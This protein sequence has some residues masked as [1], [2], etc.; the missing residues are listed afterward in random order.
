MQTLAW[1]DGR[2]YCQAKRLLIAFACAEDGGRFL[3]AD[4]HR[5]PGGERVLPGRLLWQRVPALPARE[6]DQHLRLTERDRQLTS[7]TIMRGDSQL[8]CMSSLAMILIDVWFN[9]LKNDGYFLCLPCRTR[10]SSTEA[11][12]TR[13]CSRS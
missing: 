13:G 10:C 9:R 1:E 8:S 3:P 12:R 6:F 4:D 2:S 5:S 11:S 7:T